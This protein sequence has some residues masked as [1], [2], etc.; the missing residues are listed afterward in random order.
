MGRLIGLIH[1]AHNVHIY[2]THKIDSEGGCSRMESLIRSCGSSVSAVTKQCYALYFYKP[3]FTTK[4][5]LYPELLL[6]KTCFGP[7]AHI[8]VKQNKKNCRMLA[9]YSST[10]I[11]LT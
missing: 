5:L 9:N 11:I 7:F 8:Q 2:N 4:I 3:P 10:K 1:W 6:I